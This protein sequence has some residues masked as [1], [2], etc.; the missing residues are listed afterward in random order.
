[1]PRVS[2]PKTQNEKGTDFQSFHCATT[3]DG[4]TAFYDQQIFLRP[5]ACVSMSVHVVGTFVYKWSR[6]SNSKLADSLQSLDPL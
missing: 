4:K 6:L 1:V 2:R 3:F 5:V